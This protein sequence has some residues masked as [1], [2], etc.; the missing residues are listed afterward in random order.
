MIG[1]GGAIYSSS[2]LVLYSCLVSNNSADL[3]GGAIYSD[4]GASTGM[5]NSVLTGNTAQQSGAYVMYLHFKY[6]LHHLWNEY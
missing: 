5:K 1:N 3:N 6:T 4:Y 2:S